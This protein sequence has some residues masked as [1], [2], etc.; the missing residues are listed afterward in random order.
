MKL[1]RAILHPGAFVDVFK[2]PDFDPQSYYKVVKITQPAVFEPDD[3]KE[4]WILKERG[5]VELQETK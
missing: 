1:G 4:T 5:I 2:C 3:E